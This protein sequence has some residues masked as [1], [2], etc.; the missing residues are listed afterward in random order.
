MRVYFAFFALCC[1]LG[2]QSL[3]L[4]A[5]GPSAP[6]NPP[7]VQSSEP[8]QYFTGG[9]AWV[10]PVMGEGF[11]STLR[12]SPSFAYDIPRQNGFYSI[13]LY[14]LEPNK[15]GPNQRRFTVAANG[16]QSDPIDLFAAAGGINR[17]YSITLLSLVGNGHLRLQFAASLSNAV[18]SA[19]EITPQLQQVPI[20]T[21]LAC[22]P[23]GTT[24]PFGAG[25]LLYAQLPDKSCLPI[26]AIPAA[27]S[28]ATMIQATQGT[29]EVAGQPRSLIQVQYVEVHP[30][31]PP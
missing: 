1:G 5:G 14:M 29:T 19:I 31:L 6:G 9:V 26:V 23:P 28:I 20:F 15:T 17:Q 16:M 18:V 4:N 30:V 25:V 2:A 27:G 10:D 13:K 3:F 7:S 11:W 22:T 12:Y 21:G 8:D 24:G